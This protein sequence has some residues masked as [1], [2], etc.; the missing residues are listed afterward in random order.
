LLRF[1]TITP[2]D[3]EADLE[4][5]SPME[6]PELFEWGACHEHHHYKDFAFYR[7]LAA[8]SDEVVATGHKQAFA[9]I[10]SVSIEPDP[11]PPKYPLPDGTQGISEGWADVYGHYLD[12]Q[13]V[14]ITGVE[15]GDYRLEIS[16]NPFMTFEEIR[17]DD[18]LI[19]VDVTIGVEDDGPPAVPAEWTCLDTYYADDD[20]CH[21]GCGVVDPDCLN[22]TAEA[23]E[24]C[25]ISGSCAQGL[26]CEAI[27]A[28]NNAVCG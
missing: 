14:D 5:G 2:N 16:I 9:L 1:D 19:V 11:G 7:L 23:C 13:W 27:S 4:I 24:F 20:G 25:D 10:D 18:N 26:G 21:C 3:G 17:Y 22:P 8:D 6:F 15:P 28:G 12:C